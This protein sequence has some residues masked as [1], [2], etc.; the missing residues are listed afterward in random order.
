MWID[1]QKFDYSE[2]SIN[3][4]SGK[5][6]LDKV[7]LKDKLEKKR[8]KRF[9][10]V[11]RQVMQ[12]DVDE[13]R[14]L[15]I[16]GMDF[17]REY[18]RYY[19]A[20]EATAHLV[21]VTDIDDVG[22]EGVEKAF[23]R[24]LQ[25]K[26]GKKYIEQDRYGRPIRDIDLIVPPRPGR[27]LILSIDKKIQ[28]HAYKTLKTAVHRHHASYGSLVMLDNQ[29]G[30]VMAMVNVPSFN[31]NNRN[32]FHVGALRN[33]LV[34]DAFEPGSTIKPLVLAALL[35]SD[36]VSLDSKIN[37]S[38]GRYVV[39]GNTIR[40]IH[41]YGTLTAADVVVKSSNVGIS[42]LS[43]RLQPEEMW[44]FF[45]AV[46]FGQIP[47]TG[48]PGETGGKLTN[49]TQWHGSDQA[50]MSFG[51][52]FS[53]SLLQLAYA[54]TAIT[55]DGWQPPL[56]LYKRAEGQFEKKQVLSAEVAFQLRQVLQRVVST[57]G[58]A[59]KAKVIGFSTAGKTGT[60]RK[61]KNGQY[62]EED[63][64]SVFVGF[65]PANNPRLVIAVL[66]DNPA[67]N[68]YGGK[69][70]APVFAKVAGRA[71]RVLGIHD[72][73]INPVGQET[74]RHIISYKAPLSR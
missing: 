12:E 55:N 69:I 74:G 9:V 68:Y 10:Y 38:S 19:P 5:L 26:S 52:G 1:P 42:K 41:N 20:G 29:T 64:L 7:Q 14:R 51:Y 33:R 43:M 16:D 22:I 34:T 25:G 31:P 3:K 71:L 40:D 28:Y 30:E 8:D 15:N 60:V 57:Q 2:T 58:T 24:H 73:E 21:G 44:Q 54:Y 13:L 23:H 65:V 4:I 66:I 37:V 35:Q 27:K 11:K 47:G 45:S 18:R 39:S 59:P 62:T 46:G 53:A 49:Y 50:I 67:S 63:Y 56:T 48:F 72:D 17:K 32:D 61:Y 70:A 36:L 6:F